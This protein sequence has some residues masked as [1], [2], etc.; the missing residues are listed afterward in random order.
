[1]EELWLAGEEEL[2]LPGMND[3]MW[4]GGGHGHIAKVP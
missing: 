3:M 4:K 1:M 2:W